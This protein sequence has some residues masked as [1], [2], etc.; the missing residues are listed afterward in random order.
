[1][2]RARVWFRCAAMHD[3]VMPIVVRPAVIG[4]KGKYRDIDLVI[5]REFSGAELVKRMKGWITV[6][7]REAVKVLES[8]G[9]LK[10]FETGELVVEVENQHELD[11]LE[12]DLKA[13]FDD[14]CNLEPILKEN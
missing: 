10:C 6:D 1:M 11:A 2:I 5:E 3:P 7:P 13:R 12:R 9:R 14:Q 4:W 8:H